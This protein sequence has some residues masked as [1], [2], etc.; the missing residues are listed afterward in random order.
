MAD[1]DTPDVDNREV[2]E[3]VFDIDASDEDIDAS[4]EIGEEFE[5]QE[6]VEALAESE[7]E[8]E[9]DD[10]ERPSHPAK[11][12]SEE[13]DDEEDDD[14]EADLG[15]ILKDRIAAGDDE[16]DED[17]ARKPA[18]PATDIAPKR[19]DEWTCEQCFF[20]VSKNQFG[21]RDNPR[22][23]QG[24]EPCPSIARAFS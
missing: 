22:C 19:A 11:P 9:D 3:E 5:A 24:E 21:T 16:D 1:D 12:K 7:N 18:K 23:P 13:D 10:V 17:E 14:V 15:E 4:D 6:S 8:D 20:I 2:D